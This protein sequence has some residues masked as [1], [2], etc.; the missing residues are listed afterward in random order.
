MVT[1]VPGG[2]KVITLCLGDNHAYLREHCIDNVPVVPAAVALEIMSEAASHLWPDRLVV[3]ARD[4]QLLKGIELKECNQKL[5]LVVSSPT[6][7]GSDN[8][9]VSA[10]IR[11]EQDNGMTRIHYRT[12]LHLKKQVP[13]GFTHEPRLHNE[14]NL[15]IAKAYNQWLFHGPRFQVI[16]KIYGLSD[17]GASA[18]LRTTSPAQ[19]LTGIDS[20]HN[21]W[22]FDPAIVDAAA[23]MV[24]LWTR[25]FRDETPLPT[26]FGRVVRY[27]ETLPDHLYMDFERI[28]SEDAHLV[29][30]NVY[31]SDAENNVL[32]LV[33]DM[34]CVS[35]AELNRLGGTAK[36]SVLS[37]T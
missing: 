27:A 32:V 1:A 4:C 29:R 37:S 18:L 9:Q 22:I 25:T 5:S 28:T 26:R 14:K 36:V 35:S 31:F 10:A 34:E 11:S 20:D 3:E 2:E 30:G 12:V 19:W 23:Q 7:G 33:E 15:D 13:R 6:N 17:K 8:L 16:D 24:I 21:R